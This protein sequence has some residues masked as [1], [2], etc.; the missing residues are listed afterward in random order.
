VPHYHDGSENID[1]ILK[2]KEVTC[3][4]RA[5]VLIAALVCFFAL[6]SMSFADEVKKV[7]QV[8]KRQITGEIVAINVEAGSLTVKS[9]RQ[10]VSF[11]KDENTKVRIGREKKDFADL[12]KGA[13]VKVT[14]IEVDGEKKA[15]SISILSSTEEA[16]K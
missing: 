15:K 13:K 5:R 2:R 6:S 3:M 7:E 9:K 4:K 11:E 10:E 12:K 1:P 8:K 14:Y 16:M